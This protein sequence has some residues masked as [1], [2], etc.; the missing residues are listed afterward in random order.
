MVPY[1]SQPTSILMLDSE[2]INSFITNNERNLDV[3][4]V[5]SFGSEWEAFNNFSHHEIKTIGDDY[6]DLLPLGISEFTAL[7]V[8]CG[9]GR[10][11]LY[12]SDRVKF[13]EAIDPSSSVWTAKKLLRN[14]NNIRVTHASVENLPFADNSFDLVYSLGVLHHVP[15]TYL[16]IQRCFEKAKHRGF[17]LLYLYYNLENRG[18][19]FRFFFSCSN[20]LRNIISTLP[21]SAK[22]LICNVIATLVY[23]PLAKLSAFVSYFSTSLSSKLPLSYYKKT[24]FLIMRN[25]ALD[26]FGTPLE[27]RFSKGEITDMLTEAGFVDIQ[28]STNEPYWHVIA[29]KP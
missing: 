10:W 25:D 13:I 29:R 21:S 28:F 18:I 4:T 2:R 11:A 3:D 1:S 24:S 19:I 17:F 22:K 23:W 16:A 26:R 15:N 5:L 27:K 7:D 20:I 9:S 8:G 14:L 12:L 6:F